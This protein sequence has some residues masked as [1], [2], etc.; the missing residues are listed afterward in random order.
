[1]CAKCSRVSTVL[2]LGAEHAEKNTQKA[3][4]NLNIERIVFFCK[5]TG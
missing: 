4:E 2:T 5:K 3:V 1:M